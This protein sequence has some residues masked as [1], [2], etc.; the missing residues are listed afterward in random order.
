MSYSLSN[1]STRINKLSEDFISKNKQNI[2]IEGNCIKFLDAN[3]LYEPSKTGNAFHDS[4]KTVRLVMGPYGS[5]KSTMMCMEII[6]RACQM[7][8]SPEGVRKCKVAIVRNT[9]AEL[10]TT[11]LATWWQWCNKLGNSRKASGRTLTCSHQFN[12]GNGVIELEILFLA[13]D[14]ESDIQRFKS[15]EITFAYVNEASE[16]PS[17]ALMHLGSRV[18]RFPSIG[19]IGYQQYWC[20]IILDTNPPDT[21]HWIYNLFEVKQPET[22][23][24]FKQPPGLVKQEG[25]YLTNPD[26]DNIK[27]LRNN[28]Y[29]D[30]SSGSTDEFIKVYC[31]GDYGVIRDGKPV[32]PQY[33]D[34]LHSIEDI[35]IVPRETIYLGFDG[36]LTPACVVM[37]VINGQLRAL[38]EFTTDR[39]GML[40]LSELVAMWIKKNC[41][42][43]PIYAVCDPACSKGDELN[44]DLSA[45]NVLRDR[46]GCVPAI[47]N[48]IQPRIESMNFYLNR[49]T[50]GHASYILSR[51]GCPNLR[52]GF[53]NMYIYKKL[54]LLNKDEYRDVPNKNHPF[55]DIHDCQQ[56]IALLVNGYKKPVDMQELK[57]YNKY[58]NTSSRWI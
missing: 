27:H 13:L 16:L 37:Q 30:L 23:V 8:V 7:P 53:L 21:D 9:Y 46:F 4:D 33:N 43:N 58:N 6:L 10:E 15:L 50:D 47:T 1:L 22:H 31:M 36:G 38:Y 48:E 34:D 42:E 44:S 12:D 41:Q 11:T 29:V 49:L 55:S 32:Y 54:R 14:R 5:G 35:K 25:K 3:L 18:G 19:L 20:G 24:I 40:E 28:Y 17:N 26:A 2:S 57:K 52:K 51:K 56:Y 39:M 45:F